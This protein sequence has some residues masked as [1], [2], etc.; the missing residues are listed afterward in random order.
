MS[1][2]RRKVRDFTDAEANALLEAAEEMFPGEVE[3]VKAR[4][5]AYHSREA[6]KASPEPY[7]CIHCG[8]TTCGCADGEEEG[9]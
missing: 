5:A 2:T 7:A 8:H 6:A 9:T 4:M 1:K 3:R